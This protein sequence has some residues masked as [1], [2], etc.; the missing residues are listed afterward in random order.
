MG[1]GASSGC[2]ASADTDDFVIIL[3]RGVEEPPAKLGLDVNPH[4][5]VTSLKVNKVCG[6][7]AER[8]NGQNPEL[9]IFPGDK[10]VEVNGVRGDALKLLERCK[11]DRRLVLR[12][13]RAAV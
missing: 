7:L 12:V 9:R 13:R 10:V 1:S 6:G 4:F 11:T 3:D 5:D 2:C 8:W